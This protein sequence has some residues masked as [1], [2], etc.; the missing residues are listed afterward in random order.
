MRS[1]RID[2]AWRGIVLKPERGNVF[3]LLWVDRH[4]DAYAWAARHR[5]AINGATG[6]I[7]VFESIALDEPIPAP[8]PAAGSPRC[9][10]LPRYRR[11]SMPSQ[12]GILP[13][14]AYRRT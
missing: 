3:L 4:D 8:M 14:S 9:R 12:T 5:C 11:S 13:C 6:A 10:C 1:V 7:Q 2:D